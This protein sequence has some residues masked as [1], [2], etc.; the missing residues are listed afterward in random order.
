MGKKCVRIDSQAKQFLH[1]LTL[2]VVPTAATAESVEGDH[3]EK[4]DVEGEV[5]EQ[6]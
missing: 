5:V 2:W 4:G 1:Q 3:V 6:A